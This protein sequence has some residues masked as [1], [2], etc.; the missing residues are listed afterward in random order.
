MSLIHDGHALNWD[1]PRQHNDMP[2]SPKGQLAQN[3]SSTSTTQES[4]LIRP[5]QAARK[6]RAS[7]STSSSG[8]AMPR[9]PIR[10]IVGGVGFGKSTMIRPSS[11]ITTSPRA[12]QT[13]I[14][15][16]PINTR[17]VITGYAALG[18]TTNSSAN[19]IMRANTSE[20]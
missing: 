12:T 9:I 6:Y 16:P 2:H 14:T 3:L 17:C 4:T 8:T 11:L 15:W 20:P 13:S 7:R 5:R 19:T 10:S 18:T 1:L